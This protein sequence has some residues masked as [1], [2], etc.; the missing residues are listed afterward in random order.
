MLFEYTPF[1][2]IPCGRPMVNI[3]L[4]YAGSN[5]TASALVDSG[6]DF[7]VLPYDVGLQLGLVWE[8]QTLPVPLGGMLR[9]VPAYPLYISGN[10]FY[11]TRL[12]Q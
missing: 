12:L 5:L 11:V 1:P 8:E 6:A 2:G 3:N 9:G 7:S 4:F 10:L